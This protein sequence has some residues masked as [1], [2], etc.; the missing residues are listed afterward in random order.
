MTVE[1]IMTLTGVGFGTLA[2]AN[3]A[4]LGVADPL[5]L[6]LGAAGLNFS[7]IADG[8]SFDINGDGVLDQM[9]WTSG[10]DGILALD[11]DGSGTIDNGTEIFSPWFPDGYASSLAALAS[12]DSNGDGVIDSGGR[13]VRRPAGVAGLQ[14]RRHQRRGRTGHAGGSL[15]RE[16]QSRCHA[17]RRRDQ[18]P[19]SGVAGHVP[20]MPMAAAAPWSRWASKPRSARLRV[21]R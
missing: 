16:H 21:R 2:A 8:V 13:P 5:I 3:F 10:E 12:L 6:D 14:P 9:A 18:R 19:G 7:G 1:H 17:G 20:S 11:V 4:N 15:D